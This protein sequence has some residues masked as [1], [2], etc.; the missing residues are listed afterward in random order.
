MA[1]EHKRKRAMSTNGKEEQDVMDVMLNVL[2]D[3][4]VSD[5]D[6]DTIIK[7]TCLVSVS[8]SLYNKFKR[9]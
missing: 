1:G 9:N 7:A 6:S 4:K 3:L 2:Q 8:I 5:Y